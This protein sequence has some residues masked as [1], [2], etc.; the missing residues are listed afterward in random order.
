MKLVWKHST[1]YKAIH[2]FRNPWKAQR[3]QRHQL[4][5]VSR[6]GETMTSVRVTQYLLFFSKEQC[7]SWPQ[8]AGQLREGQKANSKVGGNLQTR[9]GRRHY[10]IEENFHEET[11]WDYIWKYYCWKAIIFFSSSREKGAYQNQFAPS[12]TKKLVN[13]PYHGAQRVSL[14]T[15]Y[16]V[17]WMLTWFPL[18]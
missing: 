18:I 2:T 16:V 4:L 12:A 7:T 17:L 15:C 9:R 3:V 8:Y 14:S 13:L 6:H 1:K 10:R 11:Y 5:E